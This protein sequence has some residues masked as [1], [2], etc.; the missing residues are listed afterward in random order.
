[1]NNSFHSS[2]NKNAL[3]VKERFKEECIMSKSK[4][5]MS[6]DLKSEIA[7]ELRVNEKVR[8]E[9]WGA[10]SSRD[11]GNMV[12]KAIEIADRSAKRT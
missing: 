11:C 6:E 8:A 2:N 4:G 12:K 9:G 5:I 10:V 3:L 7:K 1:L